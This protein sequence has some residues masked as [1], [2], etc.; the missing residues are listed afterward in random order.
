MLIAAHLCSDSFECSLFLFFFFW[1]QK[2]VKYIHQ[3]TCYRQ[4]LRDGDIF[5]CKIQENYLD[6]HNL[7]Q[8]LDVNIAL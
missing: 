3:Y 2:K 8:K 6:V 4:I 7:W 1:K 5:T